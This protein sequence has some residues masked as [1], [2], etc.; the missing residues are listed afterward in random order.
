MIRDREAGRSIQASCV[1][2]GAS[3]LAYYAWCGRAPSDREVEDRRFAVEV[4]AVHRESRQTYG[5]RRVHAE[6]QARDVA[7]GRHR[8][9]RLMRESGI[10]ARGP[11]RRPPMATPST[12]LTPVAGSASWIDSMLNAS[13]T[14][15]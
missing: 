2:L 13:K 11:K 9:G 5:A 10:V 6:L 12:P 7:C 14:T 8:V 3:A 4:R 15:S 1:A